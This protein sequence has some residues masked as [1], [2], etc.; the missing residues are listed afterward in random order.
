MT[1]KPLRGGAGRRAIFAAFL[2]AA[3]AGAWEASASE[4]PAAAR[5]AVVDAASKSA[6][7]PPELARAVA[8]AGAAARGGAGPRTVGIMGIRPSLARAEFGVGA[9]VLRDAG[10]NAGLGVALLERLHGRHGGRWDLALSHY[11]GGPPA[12]CES[13]P[14]VHD[15]TLGYVAEVM[16]WWRR[17]QDGG[18]D[19]AADPPGGI[20]RTPTAGAERFVADDRPVRGAARPARFF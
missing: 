16:E 5:R 15:D 14:V 10:A 2:L 19:A 3:P 1:M 11:R 9:H 12:R 7:V 4:P 20:R 13:G 6:V 18:V 8:R 17:Y